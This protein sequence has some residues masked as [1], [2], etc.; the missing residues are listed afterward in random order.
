MAQK[1]TNPFH[2]THPIYHPTISEI[3]RDL[4]RRTQDKYSTKMYINITYHSRISLSN[5]NSLFPSHYKVTYHLFR[6]LNIEGFRTGS[7]R[8]SIPSPPYWNLR[9][10]CLEDNKSELAL[11]RQRAIGNKE[12][13][14]DIQEDSR[15]PFGEGSILIQL[16]VK[17][18]VCLVIHAWRWSQENVR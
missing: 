11:R 17:P 2:R 3:Q 15:R 13:A 7:L 1:M 16:K 9:Y 10:L 18:Y 8:Q 6:L 5:K 14:W 4:W 12:W